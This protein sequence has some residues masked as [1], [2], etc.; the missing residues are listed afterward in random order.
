MVLYYLSSRSHFTVPRIILLT[1]KISLSIQE[2]L[3]KTF[4]FQVNIF[5][6][7]RHEDPVHSHSEPVAV[8]KEHLNAFV[9]VGAMVPKRKQTDKESPF[10]FDHFFL[11]PI[12]G[13]SIKIAFPQ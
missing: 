7:L 5:E 6:A 11:T 8:R 4:V 9:P 13:I 12:V 10:G 2:A 3:K 1:F